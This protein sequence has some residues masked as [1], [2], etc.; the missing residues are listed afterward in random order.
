MFDWGGVAPEFW[1]DAIKKYSW[2]VNRS[3]IEMEPDTLFHKRYHVFMR[4][5]VRRSKSMT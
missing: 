4:K 5:K 3:S 2:D 1:K